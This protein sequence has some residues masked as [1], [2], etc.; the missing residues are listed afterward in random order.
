MLT[1]ESIKPDA[2]R[3]DEDSVPTP[4]GQVQA[5]NLDGRVAYFFCEFGNLA[6]SGAAPLALRLT[7]YAG[8]PVPLKPTLALAHPEA[9]PLPMTLGAEADGEVVVHSCGLTASVRLADGA[10]RIEDDD[11]HTLGDRVELRHTRRG[12]S[13][14]QLPKAASTHYYGL[15]ETTGYLDKRDEAYTMWNSDVFAP[16]VPEM[17]SLYVSIPFLIQ[18]NEGVAAGWFLDNPGKS[19]FDLRSHPEAVEVSTETGGIDLY[20]LAGPTL[21]DVIGRYTDLTGRMPL[22]PKWAIGYHQSRYS[23]MDETEVLLLARTFRAKSIPLDA[24]YLDI[25]Y[26]DGYRVFTFDPD[27]FP[28][29]AAMVSELREA[30]VHVVPI[31]D[32]GIKQDPLYPAYRD[33]VEEDVFC[34]SLEGDIFIGDVWP[35]ASAFPDFSEGRVREWWKQQQSFYVNMGIDGIWNDMNEPAV[36]S[37]LKTLDP[38]V[39]HA[40]DGNPRTH[41]ELH[42][43]YGLWMADATY[44]GLREGLNGE[45]PFLLTRAAYSGVQRYGAVWTGDNRSFWEHMAMAIPMVLNMGMSGIAFAGPDVGGFAHHTSAELLV[46]WTQM[47]AFFPFFRNHSALGTVR[48]EPWAF[49]EEVE[50]ILRRYISLRYRLMP[51]LYGVFREASKTGLPV[52]RPLVLEYPEDPQT[53]NLCD[54]F[55]VGRDLLVAPVTR[56]GQTCKMLYLPAGTWVNYWTEERLTGGAHVLADAPLDTLP[57]FVRAGAVLPEGILHQSAADNTPDAPLTLHVYEGES[58]ESAAF[59]LYEDDGHSLD[60]EH[61]AY[62]EV[63]VRVARTNQGVAVSLTDLHR[64]F[65][66]G[67]TNATIRLHRENGEVTDVLVADLTT[68]PTVRFPA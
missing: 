6:I 39:I 67:A 32:P 51:Y 11:G 61:G 63:E 16:H 9:G 37:D 35:G 4:L 13:A 48:Q 43:L 22:P 56:P 3:P 29:S 49:G 10:I 8:E 24:V 17:E 66:Q 65:A 46:R 28:N 53:Y 42:N 21:K 40:N 1:S 64:G 57:L 54:Q 26:M 52:M 41:A 45:R 5:Y 23:Y 62:N 44:H 18:L 27:R 59:V 2:F 50:A 25:H 7:L 20:I 58:G 34:K 55:L 60:H 19:R 47:G 36:F 15:G 38:N 33:G 31:V 68:Q 14:L 12:R 30:G